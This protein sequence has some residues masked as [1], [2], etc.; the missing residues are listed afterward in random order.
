MH[1]RTCTG[2]STSSSSTAPPTPAHRG[3]ELFA[4]RSRARSFGGAVETY[5][6]DLEGADQL[7]SLEEAVLSFEPAM[8]DYQRR[9]HSYKFQIAVDIIFHKAVDPAVVTVTPVTLR[10]EMCVRWRCT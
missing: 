9:R 2:A 4:V 1:L 6:F 3:G 10:C 7:A 8:S 5:S